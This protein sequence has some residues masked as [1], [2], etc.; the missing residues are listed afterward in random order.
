MPGRQQLMLAN[1]QTILS[2]DKRQFRRSNKFDLVDM[3]QTN[4]DIIKTKY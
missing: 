2:S 3:L 1:S 4:D